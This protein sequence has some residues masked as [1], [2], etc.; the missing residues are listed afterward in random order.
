MTD[1][2]IRKKIAIE[3]LERYPTITELFGREWLIEQIDKLEFDDEEG[4]NGHG[5][6]FLLTHQLDKEIIRI[7]EGNKRSANAG[8]I[9]AGMLGYIQL[10]TF[11]E[12]ILKLKELDGNLELLNDEKGIKSITKK[13]K[14]ISQFWQTLSEIEIAAY[15]K[16]KQIFKELEPNINGKTPDILIGLEGEEFAIEVFTPEL[17]QKIEDAIKSGKAVSVRNRARGQLEEKISRLPK[18][19]PSILAINTGFSEIDSSKVADAL[20]GTSVLLIPKDSTRPTETTR[21]KDGIV[22]SQDVSNLKAVVFYKRW[23]DS[24]DNLITSHEVKP[25]EIEGGK[26]LTQNQIDVLH[27]VFRSMLFPFGALSL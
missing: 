7:I 27:G 24:E 23:V 10:Q 17:A 19:I 25:L 18:G 16:R 12:P 3:N 1:L 21:K 2:L 6:A 22:H 9:D 13:A 20:L 5:L 14:N 11:Y 4:V 15:S 26:N 8:N